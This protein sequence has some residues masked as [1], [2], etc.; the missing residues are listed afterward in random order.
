MCRKFYVEFYIIFI[1]K[2]TK[3]NKNINGGNNSDRIDR[4]LTSRQPIKVN[5]IAPSLLVRLLRLHL[6]TQPPLAH[7]LMIGRRQ[8]RGNGLKMGDKHARLVGITG[9]LHAH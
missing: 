5:S 4:N 9:Y 3:N 2:K 7:P 6:H 8:G 1:I